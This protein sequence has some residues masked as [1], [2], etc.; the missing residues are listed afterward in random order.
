MTFYFL[1]NVLCLIEMQLQ[2]KIVCSNGLDANGICTIEPG[3]ERSILTLISIFWHHFN[4]IYF[5]LRWEAYQAYIDI[6]YL[7]I[8]SKQLHFNEMHK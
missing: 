7:S 1:K 5:F 4:F 8:K 3:Y 2:V 6:L